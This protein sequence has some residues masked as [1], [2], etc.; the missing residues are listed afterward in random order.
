LAY[1]R[2]LGPFASPHVHLGVMDAERLDFDNDVTSLWLRVGNLLVNEEQPV[3]ARGP[4]TVVKQATHS[5]QALAALTD[6]SA[7]PRV[8]LSGIPARRLARNMD[9]P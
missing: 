2:R 5:A 4:Q 9:T 8:P 6:S 1:F 7:A 3:T